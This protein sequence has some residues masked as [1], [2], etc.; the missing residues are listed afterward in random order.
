MTHCTRRKTCHTCVK[1]M[2]DLPMLRTEHFDLSLIRLEKHFREKL[3]GLAVGN[4]KKRGNKKSG[5][6]YR[7]A[8]YFRGVYIS[9]TANSIL[10]R[11]K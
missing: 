8:G 2:A 6:T 1:Q 7:I 5:V 10:V 11:E 9:R 3:L 4:T